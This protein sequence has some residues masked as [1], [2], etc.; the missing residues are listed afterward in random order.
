[1]KRPRINSHPTFDE[2]IQIGS[3][4][5]IYVDRKPATTIY[6]INGRPTIISE[7]GSGNTNDDD[8]VS[9]WRII[10]RLVA[11]FTKT[12]NVSFN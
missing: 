5:A 7:T 1:M 3:I 9:P 4:R 10:A 11:Y 6:I 12:I 2:A 8:Y